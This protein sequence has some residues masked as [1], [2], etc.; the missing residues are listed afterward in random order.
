V[1]EL[2]EVVVE[3]VIAHFAVVGADVTNRRDPLGLTVAVM[4]AMLLAARREAPGTPLLR[5]QSTGIA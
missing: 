1:A 3:A 5:D 4:V 2:L